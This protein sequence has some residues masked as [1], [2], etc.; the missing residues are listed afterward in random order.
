[1]A[2]LGLAAACGGGDDDAAAP[3]ESSTTTSTTAATTT[4]TAV[5]A[6]GPVPA[7][8]TPAYVEAVIT[9]L[10]GLYQQ[11]LASAIEDEAFGERYIALTGAAYTPEEAADQQA[12]LDGLGGVTAI[13]R[14]PGTPT[15]EVTELVSASPECIFVYADYD[16]TP[17]IQ[18]PVDISQ[19]YFI[20]LLPEE[21]DSPL[22]PTPWRLDM[23][24]FNRDGTLLED[25]CA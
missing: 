18:V 3:D 2:G 24:R 17:L 12:G 1:M 5:D 7:E 9:E 16:P 19:P 13:A 22:N 20:K 25:Q 4:T 6:T 10:A 14:P 15:V 11:A 23:L 8:I 21:N